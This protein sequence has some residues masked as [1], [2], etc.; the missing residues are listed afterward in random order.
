MDAED[1]QQNGRVHAR[2]SDRQRLS[3]IV[4]GEAN[5]IEQ[6]DRQGRLVDRALP[7]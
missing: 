5:T 2:L 4:D 7:A 6:M 3:G 1:G